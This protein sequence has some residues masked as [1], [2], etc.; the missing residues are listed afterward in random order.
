MFLAN[1][2]VAFILPIPQVIN[3]S[4]LFRMLSETKD[5]LE[6]QLETSRKRADQVL[7]LENKILQLKQNIN[8]LNSVGYFCKYLFILA[9][10]HTLH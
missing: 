1:Q 9:C 5:M 4:L 6:Q 7:E 8:Q 2:V 3:E 10:I